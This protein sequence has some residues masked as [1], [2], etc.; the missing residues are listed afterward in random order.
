[1]EMVIPVGIVLQT[2]ILTIHLTNVIILFG[3]TIS[4][5]TLREGITTII[6]L[7]PMV[8]AL[9]ATGVYTIIIANIIIIHDVILSGILQ[10]MVMIKLLNLLIDVLL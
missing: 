5:M 10:H 6:I 7:I 9:M 8:T 1:M 3:T 4:T 2:R